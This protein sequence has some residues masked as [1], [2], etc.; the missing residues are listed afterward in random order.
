MAVGVTSLV[1]PA[2]DALDV[3]PLVNEQSL[4]AVAE[5]GE[6]LQPREIDGRGPEREEKERSLS[7]PPLTT[8]SLTAAFL[9]SLP[10]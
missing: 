1:G 4:V 2:R 7:L 10:P 3:R 5:P 8:Q 6:V 9:P